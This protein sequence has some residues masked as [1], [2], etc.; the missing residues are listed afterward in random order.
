MS[1]KQ[2]ARFWIQAWWPVALMVALIAVSSSPVFGANETS[3]PLRWL[4]QSL[5]GPV[6]NAR[7][8][9][10][11]LC[12]RKSGHFIGYGMLGLTWLRAW[13]L[14]FPRMR[15]FSDLVLALLGTAL[16]SSGDEFHQ[17]F[18]P[19]RTG[20]PWDVLLDSSGAFVLCLLGL[21]IARV[22]RHRRASRAGRQWRA[23]GEH[24]PS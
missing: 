23:P 20:S 14:T 15:L 3:A 2:A 4:W 17:T 24:F 10:I 8:G 12:I 13:R 21:W 6:T 16:I 9:F 1:N 7:W 22:L 19:N 5:F 11:H 18:I